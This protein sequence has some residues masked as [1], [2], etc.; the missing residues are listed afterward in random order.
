MCATCCSTK[1]EPA[2][3]TCVM[4]LSHV[5]SH[6]MGHLMSH[7]M[8]HTHV[9]KLL[10]RKMTC[11]SWSKNFPTGRKEKENWQLKRSLSRLLIIAQHKG[12][13]DLNPCPPMDRWVDLITTFDLVQQWDLI[14]AENDFLERSKICP[15]FSLHIFCPPYFSLHIFCPWLTF[16]QT[17]PS[18]YGG[19]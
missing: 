19:S 8:N 15:Y 6:V 3:C 14:L 9:C 11:C 16:S 13:R 10:M 18:E 4:W 2:W 1:S 5:M 12:N 7:M 17:N